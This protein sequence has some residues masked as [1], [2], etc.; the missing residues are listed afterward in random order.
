MLYY[1]AIHK[2]KGLDCSEGQDCVRN[3]ALKSRQCT[4][5]QFYFYIRNNYRY[6]KNVCDGC[7][8]GIN[9]EEKNYTMIFRILE[10]KKGTYRTNRSYFLHEIEELLEQS[11]SDL[12]ERF[13]WLFKKKSNLEIE[14]EDKI[15]EQFS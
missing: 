5:C 4:S 3:T 2:S 7:Y 6:E 1:V 11:E 14:H 13:G 12:N 10:T 15:L 8:Q 9:Y